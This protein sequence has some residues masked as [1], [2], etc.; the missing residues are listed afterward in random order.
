MAIASITAWLNGSDKNYH[1]GRLLYEQ[2]GNDPL[3]L[4]II[5]TG[6]GQFHFN[7]LHEALEE[8]NRQANIKPKPIVFEAPPERVLSKS[9]AL[10]DAP[11][12]IW[13][14]RNE[15]NQRYAQARKL[16]ESIPFM[17]DQKH[18]LEAGME[19]LEHMKYVEEAWG[20]ID[21]WRETGTIRELKKKETVKEVAE[22]PLGELIR[23]E[24]NLQSTISKDRK[25]AREAKTDIDRAKIEQ[26]IEERQFKLA[27]LR[28]RINELV[29]SQ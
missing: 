6:S 15:K 25:R 11:G 21:H 4:A 29:S 19:L 5:R 1:H 12:E 9:G 3:V 20:A 2:Y 18:R 27:E 14:I 10:D 16:F 17:D 22:L 28:K 26:R 24:K 7:K 23:Q 8:L 13:T